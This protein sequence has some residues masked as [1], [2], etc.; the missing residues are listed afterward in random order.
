VADPIVA[1]VSGALSMRSM[2]R[3]VQPNR[4]PCSPLMVDRS[5][6]RRLDARQLSLDDVRAIGRAHGRSVNDVFVAVVTDAVRRYHWRSGTRCD[7]LR[8]HI[9]VNSRT[10]RTADVAGNEFVPARV[11]VDLAG[12]GGTIDGIGAQLERL[13]AE[14]AL[15]HVN[16][17]SAAVHRL[18][19][20]ISRSVIGGMMRG[21]DVLAS[22]VPGPPFPLFLA[23]ARIER[24][25]ALGPPAGAAINVTAFSY[26]GAVHLGI[27]TDA[28]AVPD[29]ALFLECLDQTLDELLITPARAVAV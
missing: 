19:R 22:N 13:R 21:V 20:R 26:D 28:A 16:T 18:G 11:V 6:T 10:A 9:P 2:V 14:P 7:R 29:R 23:G 27:T 17:V 3:L 15:H 25:V 12:E 4:T 5:P 24:F 1:I 8:L